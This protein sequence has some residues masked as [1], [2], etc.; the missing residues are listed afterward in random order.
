MFPYAK[1]QDRLYSLTGL[2]VERFADPKQRIE[3]GKIL[4]QLLFQ[5]PT[6]FKVWGNLQKQFTIPVLGRIIGSPFSPLK[7]LLQ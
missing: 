6:V 5:N 3:T 7:H 1:K 4:Y 2:T